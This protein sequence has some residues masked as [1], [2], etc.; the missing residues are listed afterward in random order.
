P[1]SRG[2]AGPSAGSPPPPV[3]PMRLLT[4]ANVWSA[5]RPIMAMA[6]RP[7]RNARPTAMTTCLACMQ[8]CLSPQR[9]SWD[10]NDR[11]EDAGIALRGQRNWASQYLP[12]SRTKWRERRK[13]EED[14]SLRGLSGS[15][16]GGFDGRCAPYE[17]FA[18]FCDRIRSGIRLLRSEPPDT[19]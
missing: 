1:A 15:A 11:C 13:A 9:S 2:L 14:H 3:G 18:A 4:V 17:I 19:T 7:T 5:L 12:Y 6:T 10:E 8:V 16:G